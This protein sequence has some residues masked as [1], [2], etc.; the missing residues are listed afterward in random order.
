MYE[1][2]ELI[3]IAERSNPDTRIAWERA[4]KAAAAVGVRQ[5]AYF[6]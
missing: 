6:P 1:L 2:P 5:S 3:D 4:R